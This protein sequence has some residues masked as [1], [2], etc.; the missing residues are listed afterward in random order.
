M[1]LKGLSYILIVSILVQGYSEVPFIDHRIFEIQDLI[2]TRNSNIELRLLCV[3]L[4]TTDVLEYYFFSS[5][6]FALL[7]RI[8]Y[9][10]RAYVKTLMGTSIYNMS[11]FELLLREARRTLARYD[12]TT[13]VRFNMP[14]V[15][16]FTLDRCWNTSYHRKS[17]L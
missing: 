10:A 14:Q 3:F 11:Y 4:N 15:F 2:I 9:A 8:C 17:C 1:T 13:V 6:I 12:S 7:F 5:V 16:F